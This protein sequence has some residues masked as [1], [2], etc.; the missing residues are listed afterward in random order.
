MKQ[1]H[2]FEGKDC[3]SELDESRVVDSKLKQC[4][5]SEGEDSKSE[6]EESRAVARSKAGLGFRRK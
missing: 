2:D 6:L 4:N 1:C 5:D 3:K